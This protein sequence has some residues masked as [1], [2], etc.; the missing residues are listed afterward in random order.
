MASNAGSG[1][2]VKQIAY[3]V[4]DVYLAAERHA[5][6][7]GSGPFFLSRH[8]AF[9]G[10]LY[11]GQAASVDVDIALGQC[12][13]MQIE[14]IQLNDDRASV[15]REVES[16]SVNQT[17]M[18]HI[19]LHPL[20]LEV[21]I[22]ECADAGYA[23]AF[24]FTTPSGTRIVMLDTLSR[25]GHFLELYERTEEIGD[26]YDRIKYASVGFDGVGLVRP[27]STLRANG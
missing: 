18:H 7:F 3:V 4:P 16:R 6:M 21:K 19:C 12:G 1:H 9:D 26:F 10:H 11:R 15:F 5:E 24:D 27:I 17:R 20:N 25:L 8:L 23:V 14:L 13:E 2:V 22:H